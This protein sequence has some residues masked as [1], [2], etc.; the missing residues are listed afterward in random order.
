MRYQDKSANR[1]LTSFTRFD[2]KVYTD[3]SSVTL[4]DKSPYF[5]YYEGE[6]DYLINLGYQ[7]NGCGELTLRFPTAGVYSFEEMGVF[8][9]PLDQY[10]GQIDKLKECDISNVLVGE[11][12]I[13]MEV[14]L[15]KSKL[16]CLAFPYDD[17]WTAYVDGREAT[18]MRAN[19]MYM[20]LALEEGTH[21]IKLVYQTKGLAEGAIISLVGFLLLFMLFARRYMAQRRETKGVMNGSDQRDI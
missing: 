18:L 14:A 2:I 19:S 17:G 4:K 10:A 7:E 3:Y 16:L 6:E 9:Q 20:G 21:S 1:W 13:S 11:N 8:A 5:E 15:D 12:Q